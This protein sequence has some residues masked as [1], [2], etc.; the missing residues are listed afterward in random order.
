[1]EK[2]KKSKKNNIDKLRMVLDNGSDKD[3]HPEDEKHLKDLSRRLK[4][5]PKKEIVYRKKSAEQK[6]EDEIDPLKPKVTIHPREA[7]KIV[8]LPEF[9]EE[10]IESKAEETKDSP[11]EDE[12]IFE[13]EK[14]EH[15]EPEFVEVKPKE[16]EKQEEF[17]P[18]HV[19]EKDTANNEELTEWAP[20]V[21]SDKEA[22]DEISTEEKV[23]D[24]LID[25]E[26]SVE[27]D[28]EKPI[29]VEVKPV[30]VK[31]KRIN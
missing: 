9:K 8:K 16:V 15:K 2:D 10:K 4:G 12:D 11:F 23:N 7:K 22:E 30:E 6:D 21:K 18:V 25:I 28:V 5:S 3:L 17:A 13:V 14:V 1:M 20:V 19:E 24:D 29:E 27:K 31:K 26:K